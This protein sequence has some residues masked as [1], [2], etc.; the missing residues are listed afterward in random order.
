MRLDVRYEASAAHQLS[1]GVPEGHKCRRL[2]GHRY[3]ITVTLIGDINPETGMLLEYSEIDDRVRGVL[4]FVDHRF[5]NMLGFEARTENNPGQA[6]NSAYPLLVCAVPIRD[7]KIV[8]EE[9]A[10]KVRENS[11]VENLQRWFEA[12][13]KHRFPRH[14]RQVG[15]KSFLDPQVYSVRIEENSRS[16]VE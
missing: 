13:L 11:T 5:I 3:V 16:G 15:A 7:L 9:L 4:G 2:H 10:A 14:S 1:A 12:E 6:L 8:E